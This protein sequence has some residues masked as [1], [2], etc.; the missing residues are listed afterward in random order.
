M[1]GKPKLDDLVKKATKKKSKGRQRA[2]T[3]KRDLSDSTDVEMIR[4]WVPHLV[5]CDFNR[6]RSIELAFPTRNLTEHGARKLA[7][8]L[9]INPK[10]TDTMAAH[11]DTIDNKFGNSERYVLDKMYRQAEAN[12]FDYFE[13]DEHG[14]L[15]VKPLKDL[16]KWMQQNVKKL[17]VSNKIAEQGL[18]RRL[19]EQTIDIEIVDAFRPVHAL[20]K[21]LGM[22]IE[23]VEI[24][25]GKQTADRLEAALERVKRKRLGDDGHKQPEDQSGAPRTIN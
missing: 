15:V 10:F 9:I 4:K 8:D 2:R 6:L 5:A 13:A 23:R 25:F 24:D 18:E 16:P 1:G 20:G 11:L 12:I 17:K 14:Q 7:H 3:H 19:I 22:F 21:N